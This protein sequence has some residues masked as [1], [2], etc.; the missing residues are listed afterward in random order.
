MR[1]SES[2]VADEY[3]AL[4]AQLLSPDI[5]HGIWRAAEGFCR[6][7]QTASIDLITDI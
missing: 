3:L 5:L 1:C 2:Y 6:T 7:G 4:A